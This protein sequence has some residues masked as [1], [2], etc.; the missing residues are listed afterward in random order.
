MFSFPHSLLSIKSLFSSTFY[1]FHQICSLFHILCFPSNLC[2]L[3]YSLLS[4]K[5][6]FFSTFSA[7]D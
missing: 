2:S 1:A 7:F 5:S 6:L 3:R 4:I